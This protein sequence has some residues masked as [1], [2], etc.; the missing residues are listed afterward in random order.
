MLRIMIIEHKTFQILDPSEYGIVTDEAGSAA[1][2]SRCCLNG[3]R[4]SQAQFCPDFGCPVGDIHRQG[5]PCE[6]RISREKRIE[7]KH[8]FLIPGLIG[9]DQD[10]KE[11]QRGSACRN[12]SGFDDAEYFFADTEVAG[13][14]FDKVDERACIKCNQSVTGEKGIHW[15]TAYQEDRSVFR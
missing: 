5:H 13:V 14:A 10:F 6:V 12:T 7:L 1:G 8:M 15:L 3:V 11:R 2:D 9:T 4:S